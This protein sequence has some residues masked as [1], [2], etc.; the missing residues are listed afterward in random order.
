[1]KKNVLLRLLAG[2]LTACCLCGSMSVLPLTAGATQTAEAPKAQTSNLD[3]I[4][5]TVFWPPN[6]NRLDV[7]EQVRLMA[8]AGIT[9]IF[10]AGNDCDTPEIQAQLLAEAESTA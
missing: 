5:I 1:M 8:E 3:N 6:P 2:I 4:V 10:G 7:E 9:E